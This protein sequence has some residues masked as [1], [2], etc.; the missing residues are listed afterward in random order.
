MAVRLKMEGSRCPLFWRAEEAKADAGRG[1]L[2]NCFKRGGNGRYSTSAF[3]EEEAKEEME[4]KEM[5]VFGVVLMKH[6]EL[7]VHGPF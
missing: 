2:Q 6:I 1:P 5:K 3:Q 7:L 4:E